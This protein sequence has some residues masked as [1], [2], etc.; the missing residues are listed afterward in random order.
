MNRKSRIL[1]FVV[2]IALIG[3]LIVLRMPVSLWGGIQVTIQNTG[4]Q[5]LRAVRLHV[6]GATYDLGDIAAGKTAEAIV[7]ATSESGLEIEFTDTNGRNN[8]L[9]AGGYFES[10]YRGTIRVSIK[11][12]VIDMNEQQIRTSYW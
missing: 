5:P 9:N 1:A 7:R 6:T 8:R 11:D 4:N 3:T 10:G 2:G 12:D